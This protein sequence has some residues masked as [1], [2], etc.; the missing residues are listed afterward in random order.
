M[1]TEWPWQLGLCNYEITGLEKCEIG[2][3]FPSRG[4]IISPP[5]YAD[6]S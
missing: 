6:H 1:S 2:V 3:C 5:S 4:K